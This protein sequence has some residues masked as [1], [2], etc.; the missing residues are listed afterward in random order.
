MKIK[1]FL[2]N[3]NWIKGHMARDRFGKPCGVLD[4][5]ATG[6]DL[7]GAMR[8]CYPD[9][10]EYQEVATCIYSLLPTGQRLICLWNDGVQWEDVCK[11]L[12]LAD[13]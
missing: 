10:K 5:E 13:V 8:V 11:I 6:W 7:L 12:R 3:G 1:D 2:N 9:Q 4:H